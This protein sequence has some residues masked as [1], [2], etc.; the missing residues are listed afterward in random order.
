MKKISIFYSCHNLGPW[1]LWDI[2][3]KDLKMAHE[4]S[5]PL[6]EEVILVKIFSLHNCHIFSIF[7]KAIKYS[8]SACM[9]AAMWEL[10]NVEN[11]LEN[12]R[13]ENIEEQVM[14]VKTKL[15]EFMDVLRGILAHSV[16]PLFKEEV[17]YF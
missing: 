4:D 15:F 14:Q 12:G 1:N 3:F 11:V 17:I 5:K 13:N 16:N 8:I 9:F 2:I 10:H 6:P 7:F